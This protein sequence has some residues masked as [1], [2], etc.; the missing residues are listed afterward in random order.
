M[1][2][3]PWLGMT[4]FVQDL[5]HLIDDSFWNYHVFFYLN[6]GHV[7]KKTFFPKSKVSWM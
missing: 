6:K 3:S 4:F 2:L 7:L 1:P 5:I